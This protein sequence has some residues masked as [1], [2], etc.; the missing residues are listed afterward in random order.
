METQEPYHI[1]PYGWAKFSKDL[2]LAFTNGDI[3][4]GLRVLSLAKDHPT[5]VDIIK[6][7]VEHTSRNEN[8]SDKIKAVAQ[9]LANKI[10]ELSL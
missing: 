3:E 9:A 6:R 2:A 5:F 4:E 8:V 7:S 10:K 1:D